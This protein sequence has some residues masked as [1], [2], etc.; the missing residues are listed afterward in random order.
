MSTS[1]FYLFSV[2]RFALLA[3]D[4]ENGRLM[5]ATRLGGAI[6]GFSLGMAAE[7]AH[8]MRKSSDG[9]ATA[10]DGDGLRGFSGTDVVDWLITHGWVAVFIGCLE[11][12]A[13]GGGT[14]GVGCFG[15]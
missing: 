6:A 9:V 5:D 10:V 4:S 12:V 7:A 2:D 13:Q 15:T 14:W 1:C 11:R 3:N 8:S